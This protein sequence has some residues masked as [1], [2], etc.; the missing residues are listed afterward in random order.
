MTAP[1]RSSPKWAGPSATTLP[2]NRLRNANCTR[3][4]VRCATIARACSIQPRSTI[5]AATAAKGT[6]RSANVSPAKTRARSQPSIASRPIPTSDETT[7]IATVAAMRRRTPRVNFQRRVSMSI[8]RRSVPRYVVVAYD[9]SG[10]GFGAIASTLHRRLCARSSSSV[11]PRRY[12]DS[13]RRIPS[14]RAGR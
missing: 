9:G 10:F 3:I 11:T 2:Y 14:S 13:P 8:G 5:T 12:S 6:I 1:V 4:A 7:P